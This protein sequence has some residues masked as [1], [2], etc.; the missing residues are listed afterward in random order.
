[1]AYEQRMNLLQKSMKK[2]LGRKRCRV[3][4]EKEEEEEGERDSGRGNG[5]VEARLRE[6]ISALE[7]QLQTEKEKSEQIGR[8]LLKVHAC[9][10]HLFRC[11]GV[12]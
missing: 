6:N 9:S 1:M 12:C 10:A 2:Q 8:L 3:D 5:A 4:R 11:C 7:D